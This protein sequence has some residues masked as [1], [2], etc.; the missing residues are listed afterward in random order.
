MRKLSI[1]IAIILFMA[2]CSKPPENQAVLEGNLKGEIPDSIEIKFHKNDYLEKPVIQT[3]QLDE[4]GTFSIKLPVQELKKFRVQLNPEE[5]VEM[6]LKPGWNMMLQAKIKEDFSLDTLNFEGKGG[7]ENEIYQR[8]DKIA[9]KA[10]DH[11]REKPARFIE[12]LDSLEKEMTTLMQNKESLD[13]DFL[14]MMKNDIYYNKVGRWN[15]YKMYAGRYNHTLDTG[16][17]NDFEAKLLSDISLNDPSLM[18]SSYFRSFLEDTLTKAARDMID[19]KALEEKYEKNEELYQAY[20][21]NY[22]KNLFNITDSLIDQPEIKK[23]AFYHG[24]LRNLRVQ[25]LDMNKQIFNNRFKEVVKD[26]EMLD[27]VKQRLAKLE[28]LTPGN[29]APEFSYPDKEGNMVHLDDLK[30]QYVYLDIWATWCGPCVGEIPNLKKLH[31]KYGDE[32]A[33]VSVSVDPRKKDWEKFVEKRNLEGYQLYSGKNFDSEIIHDYMVKGIPRFV[34][35]DPEGKI[36]DVNAPRPS[37]EQTE[38]MMKEWIEDSGNE[39]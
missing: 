26:E 30:G 21:V 31:K 13:E 4:K 33:F 1:L 32:I 8:F 20:R 29:P 5:E 34:M 17:V 16:F 38:K 9:F 3:V 18:T 28:K 37:S 10:Y 24:M 2:G 36:I 15:S 39:A 25:T 11:I 27:E 35:I 23:H 12:V 14:S 6:M 19:Q 7:Q 22:V